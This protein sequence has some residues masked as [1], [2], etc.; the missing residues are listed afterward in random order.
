MGYENLTKGRVSESGRAYSLTMVT[1]GR[2]PHFDDFELARF[3]I[4]KM[5]VLHDS[6][7]IESLAWV[8]MPDHLHWLIAVSETDLS[9]VM[10]VFKGTSVSTILL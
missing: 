10:R 7:Q 2:I 8:L 4:R 5:R 9:E 6:G 1:E 3:L